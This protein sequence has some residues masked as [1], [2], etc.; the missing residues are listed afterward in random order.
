M[1]VLLYYIIFQRRAKARSAANKAAAEAPVVW[2][3]HDSAF[4]RLEESL[5]ARGLP[6]QPQ[7]PLSD[8]LERALAEPA[9]ADLRVP[10]WELL[11]LHYRYRF[12]PHGLN[13]AQKRSLVE[14]TNAILGKLA[15]LK[16]VNG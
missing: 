16:T 14:N 15:Q 9:L 3:G 1:A 5:A 13:D 2:P 6:R 12:D 11:Q 4:Y 8:W 10:L 7:E